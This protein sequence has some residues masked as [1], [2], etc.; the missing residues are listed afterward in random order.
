[1][2]PLLQALTRAVAIC[3]SKT[4]TLNVLNA[5]AELRRH[6]RFSLICSGITNWISVGFTD[7][8]FSITAYNVNNTRLFMSMMKQIAFLHEA[9][10]PVVLDLLNECFGTTQQMGVDPIIVS[11]VHQMYLE[12]IIYLMQLGYV[13]PAL[14]ML[15]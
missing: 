5:M 10:R 1:M 15:V 12:T 8:E 3:S 6:V 14:D 4:Q 9:M 13:I 11:Q 7:P 2:K